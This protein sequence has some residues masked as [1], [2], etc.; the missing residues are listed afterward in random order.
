M[1]SS[2]QDSRNYGGFPNKPRFVQGTQIFDIYAPLSEVLPVDS[3]NPQ[4][5]PGQTFQLSVAA[6]AVAGNTTYTGVFNPALIANAPVN[7]QGFNT[8]AN[9][10][11]FQVVSCN[12]TTLVVNNA[13]GVLETHAGTVEYDCRTALNIPQ[14]SRT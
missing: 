14:N 11:A 9:N 4:F 10:G 13:A 1:A 8:A 2:V 5:I 12:A 3:R 6:T 7:I